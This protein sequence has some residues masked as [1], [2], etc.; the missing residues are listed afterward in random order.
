MH[1]ITRDRRSDRLRRRSYS[2]IQRILDNACD[3][4]AADNLADA[5]LRR[6]HIRENIPHIHIRD[7]IASLNRT[8][9]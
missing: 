3:L 7:L 5:L 9:A 8:F 4:A 6:A 1:R 2:P